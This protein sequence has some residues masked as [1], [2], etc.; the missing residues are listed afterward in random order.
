MPGSRAVVGTLVALGV[1]AFAAQL[2]RAQ[3]VDDT[4]PA[5]VS[6]RT[7]TTG[8]H[9]VVTFSEAVTINPAV[10][11][12]SEQHNIPLLDLIRGVVSVTIDGREDLLSGAALSDSEL[13]IRITAPP[14]EA[15]QAVSV[16]SNTAFARSLGSLFVDAAGNPLPLFPSQSVENLSVVPSGSRAAPGVVVSPSSLRI[17]EGQSERY[18]V[19][20]PS[21]PSSDVTV[22][23]FVWRLGAI[24]V[25]PRQMT[26]TTSNWNAPQL[27]T[28]VTDDDDDA[29]D[30]WT[31]ILHTRSDASLGR[32]A[33]LVRV[34]VDD[35]DEL[36]RVSGNNAPEYTENATTTVAT[37][38]APWA[39]G[40]TWSLSGADSEHFS[41]SRGGD[42]SFASP[43]DYEHPAD[44]NADNVYQV[45]VR[46]SHGLAAGFLDVSVTIVDVNEP[47]DVFGPVGVRVEE[48]SGTFVGTYTYDDPEAGLARW[49]LAGSDHQLFTIT[50]GELRFREA[51]DFSSP[52]DANG[53][54]R[55]EVTVLADDGSDFP[56][57]RRVTV[58]VIDGSAAT[59][60]A[61]HA[62]AFPT[63]ST[64]RF[65]DRRAAARTKVGPPVAATD[66]DG[67]P[68]TYGLSERTARSFDID[69][70]TGQ[71]RLRSGTVLDPAA[72][73]FYRGTVTATDPSGTTATVD[74]TI[75]V[76]EASRSRGPS[77]PASSVDFEW[78]VEYD[79][80]E[81]EAHNEWP[82]GLWSDGTTLWITEA[83]PGSDAG[84][85][86]YDIESGERRERAEFDL[87]ERNRAP[88][89]L[90][91]DRETVWISDADRNRLYAYD[92]ASGERA[93]HHDIVLDARNSD[94]HGL[95]SDSETL[96]VVDGEEAKL[97]AY[98][99]RS[100]DFLA[101]YRLG[102]V[103]EAP[104][105]VWSDGVTVWV[106]DDDSKG[107]VAYRLP[108]PRRAGT[109][110]LERVEDEDFGELS[111]SQASNNSPR[112]IW[113]D[114]GVMY[115]ADAS[116]SRVYSYNMPDAIDARLASLTL[117]GIDIGEFSTTRLE[118][119]AVA[120]ARVTQTTIDPHTEQPGATVAITP[121]DAD[122]RRS[123]HQVAIADG[124]EV[125]VTVTSTD[126]SRKRVYRVS[127][128][129]S[130]EASCLRGSI[131]VGV[132]L[133]SYEGGSVRDLASCAA[134]LH[135]KALH[136]TQGGF[137]V[138]YIVGAPDFVNL[139][140]LALYPGGV[141]INAPLLV[142]SDGPPAA[143][144]SAD[145][146]LDGDK[147]PDSGKGSTQP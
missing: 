131:H 62:P 119:T 147:G 139:A 58:S 54:N 25:E 38:A 71:L 40:V 19:R 124:V 105:G 72:Q 1:L 80:D 59:A 35:E 117:S 115:V 34:I 22:E 133:V 52:A 76:T 73:R 136:A 70:H 142:T 17:T 95:W 31:V 116:D 122:A 64:V 21:R 100:G 7:D 65:V 120:P 114:G 135:V 23:L 67:D 61:N 141:P 75:T 125:T 140:F 109:S 16:A 118:Y 43:P 24:R 42:L 91:S 63:A 12:M 88:R 143:D 66:Q 8:E 86:A 82:T 48:G 81:L 4:P 53:N 146:D 13:T 90:W 15:G 129:S 28:V 113:S 5:F 36:L 84:V 85:Y 98:D 26:F 97:F 101:D 46:A 57:R 134:R 69:E 79:L 78:T 96:W 44:D 127:V 77:R 123:G 138:S 2:A 87:D 68:V 112:G 10:T 102:F 92:L 33:G 49:S 55:Y 37:Y 145:K 144:T 45:G 111:L 32:A 89:G 41:I 128:A 99:L 83:G 3:E 103:N 94:A 93:E 6:A 126:G 27:A 110:R 130:A 20:L 56:G 104:R 29:Q 50:N 9:I 14:I 74:L 18:T 137:W 60:A 106:S 51:P 11:L 30:I 107:L 39:S 121:R 47:P 132:S 108:S